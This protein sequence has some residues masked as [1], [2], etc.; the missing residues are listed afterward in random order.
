MYL[1]SLADYK[2]LVISSPKQNFGYGK[3]ST[4]G[5]NL[6]SVPEGKSTIYPKAAIIILCQPTIAVVSQLEYFLFAGLLLS[7]MKDIFIL[8]ILLLLLKYGFGK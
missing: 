8:N 6:K 2:F 4:N 3:I 7:C 5:T 1:I